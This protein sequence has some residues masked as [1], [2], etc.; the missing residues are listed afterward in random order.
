MKVARGTNKTIDKDSHFKAKIKEQAYMCRLVFL[1][2]ANYLNQK[3]NVGFQ[4]VKSIY[5]NSS[6]I[7]ILDTEN[8][9]LIK[10]TNFYKQDTYFDLTEKKLEH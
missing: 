8:L 9:Q 1:N 3:Y 4:M 10:K 5:Y 7:K 6:Q 2:D